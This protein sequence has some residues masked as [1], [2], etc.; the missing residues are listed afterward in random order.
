MQI[1]DCFKQYT[2][3]LDKVVSPE[4]TIENVR[5][6]LEESGIDILEKLVRIDTHRLDIPVY[7]SMCGT[8]AVRTIGTR[9][10]MGKGGTSEQARASA[11]MELVE[12]YSFFGF[13]HE[14]G[15]LET[16]YRTIKDQAI[17]YR[18]I[19]LSV[20]DPEP[21]SNAARELF[22]DLPLTWT[23]GFDL[24]TGQDLL[25]PIGWFYSIFEYNGP[26]AG[27]S[28]EEAVLQGLCEVVERHVSSII[29][30]EKRSVPTISPDSVKDPAGRELI[31]KFQKNGIRLYLK[32]FSLNTGIPTVG[33]LA[34]DPTTFPHDSE[35]VFTAGTTTSPEKSVIRA[36]TEIAQL[37]GDFQN[38]TTY[39]PTL[40]KFGELNEAS[41]IT[42]GDKTVELQSLPNL[43]DN[44]L[45]VEIDRCANALSFIGLDVFAVDMTHHKLKI[46]VVYT[47][48]PGAHFRDR[49]R[50]TDVCYHSARQISQL[51]DPGKALKEM[52]RMSTLFANRYE[53][54]FFSGYMYERLEDPQQ[55]LKRFQR[56]LSL[57]PRPVDIASIYC[58]VGI[59]YRD[60]GLFEK[61]IEILLKG[62]SHNGASKEIY[63][64]LGYCSFK[65]AKYEEAIEQ[66][67]KVLEIDPGSAIDYANIGANLKAMGH[68]AEAVKLYEMALE[69]DP[70]I[71]FARN[72]LRELLELGTGTK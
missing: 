55:A 58:H 29:S 66:F 49:T 12:R 1:E 21:E 23:K 56:A 48:I 17:P 31:E 45:K 6:R 40:T 70:G 27:N 15:F 43:S 62:R 8:D 65:L 24:K 22:D 38:R 41:Y 14:S 63:Q 7:L 54:E 61:A 53:T 33:A 10:Q 20:H 25:L 2:Y 9:K 50:E 68:N 4:E 59:A 32:D 35:I 19:P 46:P 26:A 42:S 39:K 44:N 28:Y 34:Y 36:L 5:K 71:D 30:H 37:A 51:P 18:Y 67:E 47:I 64:Q 72:H 13:M 60:M 69:L 11:L 3:E 57:D 52:N 16:T